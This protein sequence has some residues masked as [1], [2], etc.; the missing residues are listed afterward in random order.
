[1]ANKDKLEKVT[2]Q[3]LIA[4]LDALLKPVEDKIREIQ[5]TTGDLSLA[6]Q[7]V[8]FLTTFKS[9]PA[10]LKKDIDKP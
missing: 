3:E 6:T 10:R 5:L 1:M 8:H 2:T 7:Y 9:L 4:E